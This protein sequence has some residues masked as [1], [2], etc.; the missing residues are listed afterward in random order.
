MERESRILYPVKL[1]LKLKKAFP[2][3]LFYKKNEAKFS[4]KEG[5]Q[6]DIYMCNGIKLEF[7]FVKKR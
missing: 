1:S 6:L 7:Y 2:E 4:R 3:N 5:L